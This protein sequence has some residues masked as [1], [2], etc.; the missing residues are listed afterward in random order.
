[1][2]RTRLYSTEHEIDRRLERFGVTRDELVDVVKKTVAARADT[3]DIDPLSAAGQLSY[4]FGTRHIRMLFMRNGWTLDR[5]ENVESVVSPDGSMRIVF[6]NVDSAC[7]PF[8]GPKAVSGKGPAA[9]RM[10]DVAQGRLFSFTDIP[11]TVAP[12]A[13]ESLNASVW[14]FCFL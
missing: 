12:K 8:Q 13:V 14:Y 3:I 6:Q 5:T 2:M 7:N 9:N 10:I 4:I 1:M 11:E